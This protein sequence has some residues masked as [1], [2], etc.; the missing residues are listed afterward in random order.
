M[1]KEEKTA[2]MFRKGQKVTFWGRSY[3]I[4][5]IVKK[6]ANVAVVLDREEI[7]HVPYTCLKVR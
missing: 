5:K 7:W 6:L 3:R 2:K 1:L 4:G